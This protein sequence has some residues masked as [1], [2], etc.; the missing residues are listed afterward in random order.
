MLWIQ[1]C[2][3][4]V[5]CYRCCTADALAVAEGKGDAAAFSDA[6][7]QA[8]LGKVSTVRRLKPSFQ[9]GCMQSAAA[10]WQDGGRAVN[11]KWQLLS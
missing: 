7:A 11:S 8:N 1:C 5:C 10:S 9:L 3:C 6:V 2:S 4:V